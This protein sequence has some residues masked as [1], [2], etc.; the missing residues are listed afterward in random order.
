MLSVRN[1]REEENEYME[2]EKK[3]AR[4]RLFAEADRVAVKANG[5]P[6]CGWKQDATD[7]RIG[8]VD[9]YVNPAGWAL[10][11]TVNQ[12]AAGDQWQDL[13][14][15][16]LL[17]ENPG[18]VV[19]CTDD[20]Y[21]VGLV[22]NFRLV[23]PRLEEALGAVRQDGTGTRDFSAYVRSLRDG[24]LFGRALDDLGQTVWELPRGL[25]P[26][27]LADNVEAFVRKVAAIEAREEGG[28][29]IASARVCGTVNANTT[30]FAHS[31]YV[32][33]GRIVSTGAQRPEDLEVIGKV[34][35]FTPS[36]LR[37]MADADELFD[38]L[39]LACLAKVG[40]HF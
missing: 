27:G 18:A 35:L 16:F 21:R 30:F 7:P 23:G 22:Q 9:G 13:Y 14:D 20:A 5:E 11:H 26:A 4:A 31:Q 3:P 34:R 32:V 37:R 6:L 8:R 15:Q 33:R 29:E 28:F 19:V 39:T 40:Y 2:R 17:F 24:Q 25:A 36:E 12:K 1:V 38:G 10:V